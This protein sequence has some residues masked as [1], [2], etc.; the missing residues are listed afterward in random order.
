[1]PIYN[2]TV[3]VFDTEEETGEWPAS[4]M[5]ID[6]DLLYKGCVNEME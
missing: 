6:E 2:E 5:N 3:K 1:L 4:T